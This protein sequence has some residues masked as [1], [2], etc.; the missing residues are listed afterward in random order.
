[1]KMRLSQSLVL[2][3]CLFSQ[4]ES[5]PAQSVAPKKFQGF[6]GTYHPFKGTAY[7]GSGFTEGELMQKAFDFGANAIVS[8]ASYNGYTFAENV[9]N[10]C[11]EW[12]VNKLY[13]ILVPP[14][15]KGVVNQPNDTELLK[16]FGGHPGMI[17]AAHRF[18][19]VSKQCS[20]LS[21]AI[22]DDF[23]HDFPKTITADELRD[24]KDA[25]LGKRVDAKGNVDHSS[26]VTTPHLK[27]YAVVYDH[28]IDRFSKL[29]Q[30][31]KA[32]ID[33]VDGISFWIWKQNQNYK[34]FDD[35]LETIRKDYPSKEILTGIYIFN[36][37][38]TP[39]PESIRYMFEQAVNQYAE[40]KINSLIFFSAIWLSREKITPERWNELDIPGLLNRTY[41]PFLGEGKGRV[42]DA[43]TK[44]PIKNALVTVSRI[45]NGKRLL[46]ARKVTDERGEYRFGGWAGRNKKERVDY[47]IKIESDSLKTQIMNVKLRA[48]ESVNFADTRLKK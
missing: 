17:Q 22:I 40:G 25:L 14:S 39:T 19:E 36:S 33:L 12:D 47:E 46:T 8:Q 11:R 48:G 6:L 43:R 3:L 35:Y 15:E 2:F 31:D 38:Q 20:Q 7:G 26:P 23:Y 24:I 45:V 28:Q 44:L 1:M 21:G 30:S 10:N 4:I 29:N 18:S 27:L 16:P 34:K 41:Y 32:A 37:G 9:E 5:V 42:V 13:G